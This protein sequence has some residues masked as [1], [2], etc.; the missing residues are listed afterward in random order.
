VEKVM[1]DYEVEEEEGISLG[2]IFRTIFTQKWLALII[3]AVITI[4][5]TFGLYFGYSR[6]KKAYAIS[7][8]LNLPE[9]DISINA[10]R[11]EYPDG[12]SFYFDDYKSSGVLA[13]VKASNDDYASIDVDKIVKNGAIE[14]SQ[15]TT[16]AGRT[17]FTISIKRDYFQSESVARSFMYKLANYPIDLY[18]T[19][20]VKYNVYLNEDTFNAANTYLDQLN[21]IALQVQYLNNYY[22]SYSDLADSDGRLVASY[23]AEFQ[24]WCASNMIT[25]SGNTV[26]V[27]A[28]ENEVRANKYLR[29]YKTVLENFL[30]RMVV[31]NDELQDAQ[32]NLEYVAANVK[33]TQPSDGASKLA[34][35][36]A[37]VTELEREK[38]QMQEYLSAYY[39][40]YDANSE[41]TSLDGLT[42]N[43]A[44]IKAAASFGDKIT[45]LYNEMISDDGYIAQCATITRVVYN[46]LATTSYLSDVHTEGGL[47]II[48]VFA[49]SLIVGLIIACIVAYIVGA[50]KLKKAEAKNSAT[51]S[52]EEQT[53]E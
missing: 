16:D 53:K 47:S 19:I 50:A 34:E 49:V 42:E 11:C 31:L 52:N 27:S 1:E 3:A 22:E 26:S 18:S 4:V 29:N 45:N 33:D 9:T 13:A 36:K 10:L 8:A 43:T 14:Y 23:K 41:I 44:H 48:I 15:E 5:G 6:P 39:T 20:N 40:D 28:L 2:T 38:T 30:N 17:I 7:F 35:L 37:R 25:I 46:R 32:K 24:A 12:T 51:S 21:Y